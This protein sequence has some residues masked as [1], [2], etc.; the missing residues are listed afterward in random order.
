MSYKQK[1]ETLHS[2]VGKWPNKNKQHATRASVVPIKQIDSKFV[3]CSYNQRVSQLITR[4][5]D[6][7]KENPK[8]VAHFSRCLD[9]TSHSSFP[10]L[11]LKLHHKIALWMDLKRLNTLNGFETPANIFDTPVLQWQFV[12]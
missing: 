12:E 11:K 1:S 6:G 7:Y 8:I 9:F 2:L 4:T 5:L 10:E 3:A